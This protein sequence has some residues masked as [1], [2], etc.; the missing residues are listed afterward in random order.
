MKHDPILLEENENKIDVTVPD[1]CLERA[2]R[3]AFAFIGGYCNTLC[4]PAKPQ[5]TYVRKLN[6]TTMAVGWD[7]YDGYEPIPEKWERI[8]CREDPKS[9][10][11][12]FETYF[13]EFHSNPPESEYDGWACTFRIVDAATFHGTDP[14]IL[15]NKPD[16]MRGVNPVTLFEDVN[17][18]ASFIIQPSWAWNPS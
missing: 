18:H 12:Y 13:R 8:E 11:K 6:T 17:R 16:G 4:V 15:T 7:F 9:I 3:F 5:K 14:D 2:I 10:A 1:F